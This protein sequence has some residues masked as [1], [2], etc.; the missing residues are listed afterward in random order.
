MGTEEMLSHATRLAK[1]RL[2]MPG[3]LQSEC[4]SSEDSYE[5]APMKKKGPRYQ[6]RAPKLVAGARYEVD[7]YYAP[8]LTAHWL[9]AEA[10][11]GSRDMQRDV[12]ARVR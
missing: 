4:L 11:Q 7:T 1:L 6:S 10:R 8:V 12:R 3:C 2:G 5:N 9:Y